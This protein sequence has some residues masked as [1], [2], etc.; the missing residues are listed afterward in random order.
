[1]SISQDTITRLELAMQSTGAANEVTT[2]LNALAGGG[3]IGTAGAGTAIAGY[4]ERS[5]TTGITAFAGGG[6][7]NATALVKDFNRV[8][9]V[10]TAADSVRLPV[11]VAGMENVVVNDAAVAMQVFGAGTETIDGIATATGISQAAGST[12]VYRCFVAGNWIATLPFPANQTAA[13]TGGTAALAS[14][15]MEGASFCVLTCSTQAAITKTT[16]TAAQIQ[17]NVPNFKVGQTYRLRIVNL[18]TGTLTTAGG[19]NVTMTSTIPANHFADYIITFA[20][21]TTITTAQVTVAPVSTLAIVTGV[22]TGYKIARGVHQQA[23]ASDTIVS[24]LTTV[25]AVVATFRDTPTAKQTYLTATIG[26]QAGTPAA[27]SFLGKTFKSTY[28]AADDFT[29]NISWNWC[30]IGT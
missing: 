3:T 22:A 2:L 14:G 27:G 20:T 7:T 23:A 26:D 29:D 28:A 6:Q 4:L 13:N 21:A 10:A 1:M 12:V 9:T 18:N 8:T 15:D 16:R 19:S 24:G 25:V 30:A 5:L 17:A 11:S